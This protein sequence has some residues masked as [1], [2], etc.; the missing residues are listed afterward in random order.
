MFMGEINFISLKNKQTKNFDKNNKKH[1]NKKKKTGAK[2]TKLKTQTHHF[3]IHGV[4]GSEGQEVLDI[5]AIS[6]LVLSHAGGVLGQALGVDE[7]V[8][9]FAEGGQ[10]D[11]DVLR[12][13]GHA[14]VFDNI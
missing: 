4:A 13:A 7:S 9:L 3:N 14:D 5:Q 10:R 2:A 1:N 11:R 8:E 12:V 6:L